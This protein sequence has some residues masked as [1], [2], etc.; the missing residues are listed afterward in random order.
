MQRVLD[1]GCGPGG[2]VLDVAFAYPKTHVV[3]IDVSPIMIEYAHAQAW[4]QGLNNAHFQVMDVR[5]RLAFPD[6]HFDLINIRLLAS[7]LPTYAWPP[8]IQACRRL[9]RPGGILR[10]TE[11][12]NGVTTRATWERIGGLC[13]QAMCQSVATALLLVGRRWPLPPCC[14]RCWS[15]RASRILKS[16]PMSSIY[17]PAPLPTWPSVGIS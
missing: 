8:L 6:Q 9:L 14:A 13:M 16:V 5:E 17:P 2:W 3:G 4:A 12:E 10:L 1:V 7:V 11:A 15:T